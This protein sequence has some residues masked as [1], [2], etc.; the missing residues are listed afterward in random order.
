MANLTTIK[1]LFKTG[2]KPTQQQF[3]DTWDSFWHKDEMIPIAKIEGIDAVFNTINNHINSPT[4]H[5]AVLNKSRIYPFG[6]L[7]IFKIETNTNVS[8]IEAG[9]IGVGFLQDGTFIPFGKYISGN[10]QDINNWETSP[11]TFN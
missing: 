7:Q 11:I 8:S 4:A 3:W 5:A 2:L 9:D 6:E 10:I 1:N